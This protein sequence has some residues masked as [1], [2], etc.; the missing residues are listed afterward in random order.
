MNVYGVAVAM[1]QEHSWA[2]TPSN[3]TRVNVGTTLSVPS[4]QAA[5]SPDGKVRRRPKPSGWG[6]EPVVVRDRE[7]RPHGEGVQQ[8]HS[9]EAELG[10]RW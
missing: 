3:G 10:G 4:G 8:I 5:S 6:G 1:S 2:P 7:S 9:N